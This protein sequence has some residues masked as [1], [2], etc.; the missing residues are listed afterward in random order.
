MPD[1]PDYA[2]LTRGQIALLDRINS[3]E[4]GLAVLTQLVRLAQDV[5]GGR[6]AG[7]AE[8]SPGHGR[9]IAASGGCEHALGLRVERDD[10][11]LREGP[12]TL[13]VPI[14]SLDEEFAERDRGR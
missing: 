7:F 12:R 14:T 11:R 10:A 2:A 13:L 1:R 9:V 4:A 6:G 8:Y 3:G 5:L